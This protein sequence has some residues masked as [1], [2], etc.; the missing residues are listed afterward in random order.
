[1]TFTFSQAPV[2]FALTD[3]TAPD[4]TLSNLSGSGTSYTA[5]F[6]A[7]AGIDDTSATV[8]VTGG[9]YHDADG[10]AGTGGSTAPFTVD[11]VGPTVTSIT[12]SGAGITV[13]NGDL[14]AGKNVLLTADFTEK[15]TVGGH[16]VLKLN[17]RGVASY[18]SGSGTTALTFAYTVA[19]GQ[20]TAD[21][22][23]TGLALAGGATIKDAAGNNAVLSGAVTNP[24]GVLQIDTKAPT[25][26]S[27]TTS[28]AGITA[29]N[30]DLDAGKVVILTVDL[31]EK[32]TVTGHPVL[33]LN[34]GGLARY[35]SGSGTAAL[36]F[37][38]T[39]AA[40]Q[41]TADLTVTGVTLAGGATIKDAAGNNA[42]LS[43]A[44]TN[45]AGVLQIDTKA[46]TVRWIGASGDWSTASDWS[47]GT[48][49]GPSDKAVIAAPGSYTVSVTTAQTVGSV[50]LN[51]PGAVLD[52]KSSDIQ[53]SGTLAVSGPVV[54]RSGTL[55]I[56]AG[57]SGN[58][59]PGGSTL[60]NG[61]I[62]SVQSGG[63]LLLN[64]TLEGGKLII[65]HG[66]TFDVPAHFPD[67]GGAGNLE[68]VT[69]LGGLTLNSGFLRLSGT[70]T[71]ENANGTGPGTIT[72][73]GSGLSTVLSVTGTLYNK[74]NLN[75]GYFADAGVTIGKGGLLRGYGGFYEGQVAGTGLH[76]EGTI[77]AD[78]NGQTLFIGNQAGGLNSFVNDGLMLADYGGNISIN[79]GDPDPFV[80][81]ASNNADGKIE[82]T[83]SG[84]LQLG[85]LFTNSGLIK[86][87]NSTVY[88]G[89]NELSFSQNAGDIVVFGGKLFLGGQHIPQFT[90]WTDT[91][92]IK[93]VRAETEVLGSGKISS[94][95]TMSIQGGSLSGS[96]TVEDDGQIK[97]RGAS[98]DLSSLT[99]GAGGELS[100]SGTA[101]DPITNLG[102]IDASKRKLDLQGAVTG[103]G[104]LH[105]D[106]KATLE[107]GGP[108]AEATTF[109][110]KRG[111]LF[112]DLA[113]DFTGTVA[114]M[115]GRDGI[116]LANFA[117]SSH[118]SITNVTGTGAA[119]STTDVTI[120]DGSQTATI[121]LLNQYA[122]QFAVSASAY[123]L[124]PDRQTNS[125]DSGTLF[126][127]ASP[128]YSRS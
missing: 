79:F 121:H 58:F 84:I 125:A 78:V 30:G 118:P 4:G 98:V 90:Q 36:T 54:V 5:T 100:G 40:G 16:P 3:V 76:N 17:D 60:T 33:K 128:H 47:T 18:V 8:S 32:V 109:E 107:L 29:G 35:V 14:D 61:S 11:T 37:A 38:Y 39:V 85:G 45:P 74:I 25:I 119:G 112:L 52:I 106:N 1:M 104:Q 82:V 69:V 67:L 57:S 10:N 27:V 24:V 23:V 2:D 124:T 34:D 43:G 22:A 122:N 75:G 101:A 80:D 65:R 68:N 59:E 103:D 120:A 13:G 87:V 105:I 53:P 12:T 7:K 126:T 108:T 70:T 89:D 56:E 115:A 20:N 114:G 63:T 77:N 123:N 51:D 64:G 117:F 62:L 49:P 113:N 86:A 102:T 71:I 6:T 9:S 15:V 93:A 19:A 44:I 127:L 48:V 66:G 110:G 116:D 88:F 21:L 111:T 72:L 81:P 50:F 91:G 31:S 46:P 92:L 42:V 83:D 99:I 97:L 95:G 26:K 28:G 73:N 55:E 41:N 96:A 94:G